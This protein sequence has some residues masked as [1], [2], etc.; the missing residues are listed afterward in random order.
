MDRED[1][2]PHVFTIE[3]LERAMTEV[4]SLAERDNMLAELQRGLQEGLEG[5]GGRDGG[6]AMD[7][8][9]ER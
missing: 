1:L 3:A 8:A 6:E 9:V 5:G 7:V 2:S 4:R